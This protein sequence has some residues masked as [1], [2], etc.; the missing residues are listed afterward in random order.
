MRHSLLKEVLKSVVP[1][2]VERSQIMS[3]VGPFLNELNSALKAS[4]LKAVAV[5]G[6]SYAK[7][8]W[9][10]GD[11]DVDIFVK[12][13]FSHKGDSLSDL[14]ER[15]L[16]KWRHERVHG[17]RDYFWVRDGVKYEIVPVL[18]IK[19]P[20]QAENITDFSPMHVDWVNREGKSLK[21]DIRLFKKFC[22]SA[23]CY[24][25][26]S[27]IRGFSGHVA[28]IL[29]IYYNGFIPALRA[30]VKWKPKVVL[31]YYNTF[32]GKA[33]LMLNSSKTEG[34][35]IVV[36]PVQPERNA[37][38]AITI[39]NFD[40]FVLSARKFLKNPGAVFFAEKP[41]DF[42]ALEK[43]GHLVKIMVGSIDAKEDIA[44]VKF[45]RSFEY[46]RGS[47]SGFGIKDS[48]WLWDKCSSGVWWFVL[49]KKLLPAF[50]L[51]KGPPLKFIDAV[52]SFRKAHKK[53]FVRQGRLC[54]NIFVIDRSPEAVVKRVLANDFIKSRVKSARL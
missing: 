16:K 31:D 5:L 28:D 50:E 4:R 44:G 27:Y 48:G 13:A 14:L 26:E 12:F 45:V 47:L 20:E 40:R 54:A 39:E 49:R 32:K 51:H 19:K 22:K 7:D 8:T 24:G 41:V 53:V 17:S 42:D 34:P 37:S 10:S 11:Y 36:D 43:K 21:N 33:L 9:L 23:H 2:S 46:L 15:V 52:K 38:A 25:A 29:V 1:S 35:L 3:K 18:G 6:G 30:A